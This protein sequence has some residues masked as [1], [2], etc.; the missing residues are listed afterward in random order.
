MASELEIEKAIEP[1]LRQEAY[2][3]VDL[4]FRR[5]TRGWTL[6]VFLDK[7]GGVNLDDCAYMSDRIGS[8]LDELELVRGAYNLEISSPGIDRVVK[9]EKDFVRFEGFRAKLKLRV[10][11]EGQRKLKGLIG[12]CQGGKLD[13]DLGAKTVQI[14]LDDVEEARLDPEIKP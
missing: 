9:K 12:P 13:L 4:Q 10:P 14:N 8:Y 5:E 2:E 11:V 6:R 7:Q 3:L 1:L